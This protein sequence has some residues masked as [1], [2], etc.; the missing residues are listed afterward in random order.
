MIHTLRIAILI[1]AALVAEAAF[2]YPAV[3]VAKWRH[4]GNSCVTQ[5]GYIYDTREI[6]CNTWLQQSGRAYI[7][8]CNATDWS[9]VLTGFNVTSGD[10]ITPPT[11][12]QCKGDVTYS[13]G[14]NPFTNV[15]VGT[16]TAAWVLSCPN[17]GTLMGS[18][19]VCS[20]DQIDT[21]SACVD[22]EACP[23]TP[24]GK[25]QF[26]PK[27]GPQANTCIERCP[28]QEAMGDVHYESGS[29]TVCMERRDWADNGVPFVD[30]STS[31]VVTCSYRATDSL[32]VCADGFCFSG[33][34]RGNGGLCG[35]PTEA[36]PPPD[37]VTVCAPGD[38]WCTKTGT[39]ASGFVGASFNGKE[40]CVKSDATVAA[41]PQPKSPLAPA[42]TEDLNNPPSALPPTTPPQPSSA[43]EGLTPADRTVLAVGGVPG[44]IGGGGGTGTGKDPCGLPG[45]PPCKI[46]ETGTPSGQGVDSEG[47]A[48]MDAHGTAVGDAIS[49]VVGGS[50]APS[51]TWGFSFN[52]PSHCQPFTVDMIYKVVDI[53]PCAFQAVIH[54][55]MSL[56]WIGA[57]IFFSLGMVFRTITGGG[58]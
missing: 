2:A 20:T 4:D 28:A 26:R 25:P 44:S 34:T 52:L 35:Q 41:V 30:K 36:D 11:A 32:I 15:I 55:L 3:Q 5:T 42:T 10:G 19:C 13:G 48:A 9:T 39:C 31:T 27:Y 38:L 45:T 40:I 37:D 53:D 57:T 24:E 54:D 51:S 7:G 46:D 56:I 8:N 43:G 21:G 23:G 22:E 50:G 49:G 29:D 1:L 47:R 6:A 58:A 33:T 17:G 14:G 12:G 18:E 16:V